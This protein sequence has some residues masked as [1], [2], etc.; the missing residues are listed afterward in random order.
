MPQKTMSINAHWTAYAYSYNP[1]LGLTYVGPLTSNLQCGYNTFQTRTTRGFVEFDLTPLSLENISSIDKVEY[2]YDVESVNTSNNYHAHVT[3]TQI[4]TATV[5]T[6]LMGFSFVTSP[7]FVLNESTG[8]HTQESSD[9]I[10]KV[11]ESLGGSNYFTIWIVPNGLNTASMDLDHTLNKNILTVTYSTPSVSSVSIQQTTDS[12]VSQKIKK[13]YTKFR[14]SGDI[15]ATQFQIVEAH[16]TFDNP[17]INLNS[18]NT[19]RIRKNGNVSKLTKN[20]LRIVLPFNTSYKI[21]HRTK[22]NGAWGSWSAPETFR[23]RDKNYRYI[24]S[25]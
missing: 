24:R 19:E 6:G 22:S 10:S 7:I 21:R 3:T 2:T 23:T 15:S 20:E 14:V 5:A 9:A 12:T 17:L 11:E 8:V 4:S 16:Q 13:E 25:S 1:G 18:E